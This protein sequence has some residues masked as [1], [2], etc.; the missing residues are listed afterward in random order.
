VARC[1]TWSRPRP[2]NWAILLETGK[3]ANILTTVIHNPVMHCALYSFALRRSR[4][5]IDHGHSQSG[6]A[7]RATEKKVSFNTR[8]REPEL[9]ILVYSIFGP[10]MK[11]DWVI[12]KTENT[13]TLETNGFQFYLHTHQCIYFQ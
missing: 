7:L 2:G 3:C 8:Q 4:N 1:I 10:D 11:L 6:D 9:P 5:N 12:I 13:R